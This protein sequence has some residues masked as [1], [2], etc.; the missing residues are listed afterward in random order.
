MSSL[1]DEG[2]V[3]T[4]YL[5]RLFL[6]TPAEETPHVGAS[7]VARL[8]EGTIAVFRDIQKS[9]IDDV[10]GDSESEPY[11]VSLGRSSDRLRLWSDGYGISSG[12]S[13]DLFE[14]SSRL[15]GATLEILSSIASTWGVGLLGKTQFPESFTTKVGQL[16]ELVQ[17]AEDDSS[18]SESSTGSSDYDDDDITQITTDLETDTRSLMELDALFS[19]PILDARHM[20]QFLPSSLH[21]WEPH[22]PYKHIIGNRFP[23]A[24]DGLITSLGKANY[25]RFLR[26]QEQRNN[27]SR[28]L[29]EPVMLQE[30]ENSDAASSKFNDSGLGSSIPSS[31]AETIMSYHGGEGTSIRLP[32]L[33]KSARNGSSFF[34]IA[35]GLPTT[36]Q[37]NSAWKRHLFNDLRPWQCLE[38]SCG[39]KGIFSTQGDWVS[40]LALDHFA[41]EWKGVDCPLCRKDTGSGKIPILKHLGG[42]L[43]EVSLAALPSKS[44]SETGS[45]L[46]DASH[47]NGAVSD[48]DEDTDLTPEIGGVD[49]S[50]MELTRERNKD[51]VTF[52]EAKDFVDKVKRQRPEVYKDFL[53]LLQ[54]YEKD[55]LPIGEVYT[56]VTGIFSADPELVEGFK[57]FLPESAELALS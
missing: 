49:L 11:L 10:K 39:H 7:L 4:N 24:D 26:G 25:E 36:V 14:R 17:E 13:D 18:K 27:S 57:K 43:E 21:E 54:E 48:I 22:E 56:R 15:R 52:D 45:Q 32:S 40:H 50:H 19:E 16:R 33:P 9:P 53:H 28:A 8:A 38:P 6:D 46:S 23:K 41:P 51:P 1:R 35:C 12:A 2:A 30:I 20:R 44:D 34:C 55:R 3:D 31:Y 29:L 37:T 47:H 42:H 5:I